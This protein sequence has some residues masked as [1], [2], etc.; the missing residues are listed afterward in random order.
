M[1]LLSS[2]PESK[3]F[4][5]VNLLKFKGQTDEERYSQDY[6]PRVTK[7]LVAAGGTVLYEGRVE[8]LVIGAP[9]NDWDA[10][11][12]VRWPSKAAFFLMAN[13]PD[14]AAT[15]ETRV[16]SLDAI[17]LLLTAERVD[18]SILDGSRSER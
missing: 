15:Q 14:F 6:A 18:T 8:H 7:L 12:L 3:P 5:M 10:V 1:A 16:S 13:H 11:W 9:P 4:V 2:Y 17:A